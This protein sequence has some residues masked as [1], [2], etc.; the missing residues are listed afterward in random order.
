MALRENALTLYDSWSREKRPFE[1]IEPGHVGMYVCGPTV[2]GDAHLGH[3]KSYV[4]FDVLLR[5]LRHLGF[6]VR[7][8]QNITDVGHLTDDADEGEDKLGRKAR[9]DQVHPMEIAERY[10]RSYLADMDALKVERADI[11]PRATQHI[12]E[13]IAIIEDLVAKGHAYEAG[14]NVYFSVESWAEYG[15]LSGRQLDEA[16]VGTRVDVR[17]DKRDPRDFALWKSAEGGHILRWNS[18]W[19]WGVPGLAHRV[20]GDGRQVPR[21]DLRHP[22]RRPRQQVP[23]PRMRD[24]AEP[25]ARRPLRPLV[26]AQQ[27][28]QRRR[29]EDV[30]VAGQLR[31]GR[32]RAREARPGGDSRLRPGDALPRPGQLHRRGP[33]ERGRRASIA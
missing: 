12:P 7:Y 6:K 29:P 10:T 3:A 19:G 17:S 2:Y 15:R 20:L 26:D 28:D 14:G 18:P 27:H 8:V 16:K 23:P 13:Q 1:P 5:Y 32:R 4:S 25:R 24:R 11:Y 30:Q 31:H 9:L 33:G 22:W 21:R